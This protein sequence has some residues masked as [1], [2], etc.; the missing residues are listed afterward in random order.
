[1]RFF[2]AIVF[3]GALAVG[4]LGLAQGRASASPLASAA[5]AAAKSE[6]TLVTKAYHYGRPH[7]GYRSVRPMYRGYRPA[8]RGSYRPGPR[9]VCRTHVR[10]VRTPYGRVVR[11]PVQVCTRR[12]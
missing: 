9:V 8:Y 5:M 2:K 11:R 1:M 3:A 6:P 7:Y 12:Y 10:V 4:A